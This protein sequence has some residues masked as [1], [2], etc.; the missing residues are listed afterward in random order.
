MHKEELIAACYLNPSVMGF[1]SSIYVGINFALRQDMVPRKPLMEE[2]FFLR[3]CLRYS[4]CSIY[5]EKGMFLSFFSLLAD[6]TKA[7]GTMDHLNTET[8]GTVLLSLK[9]SFC[10]VVRYEEEIKARK[11]FLTNLPECKAKELGSSRRKV[12]VWQH[13]RWHYQKRFL[14]YIFMILSSQ[15]KEA[16]Y[17]HFHRK[18]FKWLLSGER[19]ITRVTTRSK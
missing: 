13:D 11:P 2:T 12:T 5:V 19:S 3:E 14:S 7:Q 4:N 1:S 17:C 10:T 8:R 9:V 18:T 16:V 15:G 6:L